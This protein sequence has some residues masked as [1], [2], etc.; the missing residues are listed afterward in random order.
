MNF[1][2]YFILYIEINSKS[3]IDLSV[4]PRIKKILTKNIGENLCNFG[5]DKDVLDT[6]LKIHY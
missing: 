1:N 2:L 5:L 4:K 6:T 3:T